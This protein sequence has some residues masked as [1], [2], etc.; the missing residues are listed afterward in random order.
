MIHSSSP[1]A[2]ALSSP[3]QELDDPIEYVSSVAEELE[4]VRQ[5]ISRQDAITDSEIPDCLDWMWQNKGPCGEAPQPSVETPAISPEELRKPWKLKMESPL[6]S[7]IIS[8]A[9]KGVSFSDIVEDINPII[10]TQADLQSLDDEEELDKLFREVIE[11]T[12]LKIRYEVEHEQLHAA[13]SVARMQV[14]PLDMS[15]SSPPWKAQKHESAKGH[16]L[17]QIMLSISQM[18]LHHWPGINKIEIGMPWAP[19]RPDLAKVALQE[20][21]DD[22]GDLMEFLKVD[23]YGDALDL[24]SLTWKP[25]GFRLLSEAHVHDGDLTS[26]ELDPDLDTDIRSWKRERPSVTKAAK[27]TLNSLTAASDSS[28]NLREDD[29][30]E[31]QPTMTKFCASDELGKFMQMQGRDP[32]RLKMMN[33]AA[34]E[35]SLAAKTANHAE[36]PTTNHI[37]NRDSIIVQG[38]GPTEQ[39]LVDPKKA[40]TVIA[41]SQFLARRGLF[42]ALSLRWPSLDF[43]ERDW[44]SRRKTDGSRPLYTDDEGDLVYSPSETMLCANLA[45]VMQ[46]ALPG[47][48]SDTAL[49][50]RIRSIARRF[51]TAFILISHDTP[52]VV[53][54][55]DNPTM[56]ALMLLHEFAAGLKAKIVIHLISGGDE[57]L[58]KWIVSIISKTEERCHNL[59]LLQAETTWELFLRQA[60][61][62]AFAS[63][64]ILD[65]LKPCN[66]DGDERCEELPDVSEHGLLAVVAMPGSELTHRFGDVLG[67]AEL[68]YHACRLFDARWVAQATTVPHNHRGEDCVRSLGSRLP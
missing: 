52:V 40:R 3:L 24:N 53:D 2:E 49:R 63:Q 5:R 15:V 7:P 46:K 54:E 61:V 51:N 65:T 64:V 59:R 50:A 48:H 9:P 11:P 62:N 30:P 42:R 36:E 8:H 18:K 27:H 34:S 44:T 13:D 41:S 58:A 35:V 66:S 32:K 45:Q 22:E 67:R 47:D 23:A 56:E 4:E 1:R 39:L 25:A 14:P 17:R 21:L 37:V 43:V 28:S 10:P 29:M 60:G 12:A 33:D 55:I 38:N 31:S 26:L 16:N 68:L 19:F 6:M 20:P 57:E